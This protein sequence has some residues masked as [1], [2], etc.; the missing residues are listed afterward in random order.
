[1]IAEF[2]SINI[3]VDDIKGSADSLGRTRKNADDSP[4]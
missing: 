1:M 3:K 4:G 2:I